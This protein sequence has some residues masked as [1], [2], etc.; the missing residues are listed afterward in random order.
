MPAVPRHAESRA[1]FHHVH[2]EAEA[3]GD[4]GAAIHEVAEE[5]HAT[6]LGMRDPVSLARSGLLGSLD[7]VRN[8]PTFS[9]VV[10]DGRREAS[11]EVGCR[12]AASSAAVGMVATGWPASPYSGCRFIVMYERPIEVVLLGDDP[13]DPETS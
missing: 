7:L 10:G 6:T 12:L 4:L 9:A 8:R 2:R 1:V 13:L 11:L 5:D 3:V